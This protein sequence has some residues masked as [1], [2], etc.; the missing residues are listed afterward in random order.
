MRMAARLRSIHQ[1]NESGLAMRADLD[2][3][4]YQRYPEIFRDRHGDPAGTAMCWGF[5]CGDGWFTLLDDLCAAITRQVSAGTTPPVVATQVK[6]KSGYLRFRIRDGFNREANPEAHRLIVLAQQR[7]EQ[8]CQACG[9][10][11]EAGA[12]LN[13]SALCARCVGKIG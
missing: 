5:E 8:T 13:W 1:R 10:E 11:L 7:S 2:Q 4:L 6:E 12:P 3:L 9:R